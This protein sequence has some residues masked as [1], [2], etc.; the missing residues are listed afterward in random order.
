MPR[1]LYTFL[2]ALLMP[3]VL[4]WMTWRGWRN[5]AHRGSLRERLAMGLPQRVD[6]P[7]WLHAASVGE[8]QSLA[9]LVRLLLQHQPGQSLLITVGSPHGCHARQV[10]LQCTGG[11]RAG[12]CAACTV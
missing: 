3:A 12:V 4:A 2:L 11:R 6:R 7:V 9:G 1:W 5:P 10:A 8:V